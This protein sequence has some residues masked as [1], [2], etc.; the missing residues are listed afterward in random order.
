MSLESLLD[1]ASQCPGTFGVLLC[2]YEGETVMSRF[3]DTEVSSV[4]LDA[5]ASQLPGSL[6]TKVEAKEY[7]LRVVG[8]ELCPL[9]A[10]FD[11]VTQNA[12]EGPLIGF[13]LV[14]EHIDL[15][16]RRLPDDYYLAFV[17][18]K[19]RGLGA[20]RYWA[21]RLAPSLSAEV[22]PA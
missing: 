1:T 4:V 8:A 3:G 16:V 6:R 10:Q 19:G 22:A 14:F 13:E 18:G 5:A 2:D 21:D 12:D 20:A 15:V 7:L 9:L 17:L 11:R